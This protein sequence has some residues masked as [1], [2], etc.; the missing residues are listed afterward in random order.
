MWAVPAFLLAA[1]LAQE[2]SPDATTIYGSAYEAALNDGTITA[3]ER[4]LLNTLKLSLDLPDEQIAAIERTGTGPDVP[5]LDQSGRWP[6]VF[7]NMIYGATIYG[8]MIPY[9][10][11]AK[12]FKWV[13]GT[14]MISLGAAYYLTYQYTK[15]MAISHSRAQMMRSGSAVG[16]RYG[17]RINT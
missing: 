3:D 10:V 12:D 4:A 15:N 6:L 13:V 9:V 16:L 14:E 1:P 5:A 8:W 2:A 11:D 7:Q 17:I